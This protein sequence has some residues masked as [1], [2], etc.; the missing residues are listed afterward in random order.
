[1][2]VAIRL[3]VSAPFM[4]LMIAARLG[5]CVTS[6][7]STFVVRAPSAASS[8]RR[9]INVRDAKSLALAAMLAWRAF[10]LLCIVRALWAAKRLRWR[11]STLK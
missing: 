7:I 11:A 10:S 5:T 8:S 4:P 2:A 3:S 9:A 1:M 6:L